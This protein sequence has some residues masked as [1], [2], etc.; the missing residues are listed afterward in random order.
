MLEKE[1]LAS[2]NL[3]WEEFREPYGFEASVFFTSFPSSTYSTPGVSFSIPP[4]NKKWSESK[5][6]SFSY[7]FQWT[8]WATLERGWELDTFFSGSNDNFLALIKKLRVEEK[9]QKWTNWPLWQTENSRS[10]NPPLL[11]KLP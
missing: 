8:F 10:L 1:R 5:D 3:D 11:K 7:R 6:L 4:V 2:L 9:A